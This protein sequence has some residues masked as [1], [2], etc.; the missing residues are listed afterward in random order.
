[1]EPKGYSHQLAKEGVSSRGRTTRKRD[2]IMQTTK[3]V[4]DPKQRE[5]QQIIKNIDKIDPAAWANRVMI[6]AE[7]V[8]Y[9]PKWTL[10]EEL[11]QARIDNIFEQLTDTIL[12]T[13]TD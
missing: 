8:W 9:R 6:L 3:P 2:C 5:L 12:E 1:M 11:I 13:K 10:T 7:Q 4:E